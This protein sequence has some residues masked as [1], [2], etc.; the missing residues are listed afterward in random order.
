[1]NRLIIDI[2]NKTDF[3]NSSKSPGS[4]GF[5]GDFY[6]IFRDELIPIL[7]KFFPKNSRE[8]R[9]TPKHIL[10]HHPHLNTKTRQRYKKKEYYVSIS[11]M[12]TDTK[13]PNKILAN[14]IRQYIKGSHTMIKWDLFQGFFSIHKL[15]W[16]TILTKWRI[17][18]IWS[19]Q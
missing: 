6:P 12:N 5:T 15:V 1:M 7:L 17:K 10:W 4:D 16:Y 14:W 8:K 11:L 2:K 18:T 19:S 3:K 9:N 13:I